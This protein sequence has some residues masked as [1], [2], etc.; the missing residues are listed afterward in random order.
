MANI[1]ELLGAEADALLSYKA[2]G[3]TK[4]QLHLPGP[5]FVDDVVAASDRPPTV[6]RNFNAM[7]NH[8]RLAGTGYV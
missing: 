7:L 3:F 4:D 1:R 5:N 6:L 8:G 2:T